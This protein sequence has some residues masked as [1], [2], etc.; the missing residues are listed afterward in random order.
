MGSLDIK[1]IGYKIGAEGDKVYSYKLKVVNK[2][3]LITDLRVMYTDDPSWVFFLLSTT[4]DYVKSDLSQGMIDLVLEELNGVPKLD[5]LLETNEEDS[6]FTKLIEVEEDIED[7]IKPIGVFTDNE[8][9]EMLRIFNEFDLIF[10]ENVEKHITQ[11][12]IDYAFEENGYDLLGEL[13]NYKIKYQSDGYHKNDGQMVEYDFFL[14]SPSGV[15][16]HFSTEMC[17]M[18]GWNYHKELKIN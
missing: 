16:T 8:V 13:L 1:C 11:E 14:T 17:L 7:Y 15:V 6:N 9:N 5:K 12:V 18:V 4:V 2:E 3:Y 10:D